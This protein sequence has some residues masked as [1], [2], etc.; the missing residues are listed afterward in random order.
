MDAVAILQNTGHAYNV[1]LIGD[2]PE[3]DKLQQ[4][5]NHLGVS[6]KFY[7][8]CYEEETLARLIMAS[9]ISVAPGMAG[10]TTMQSLA[11]GTPVITHGD[12]KRQA[13]EWEA[14]IPGETGALFDCGSAES[15][16]GAIRAWVIE[17]PDREA[18]RQRC[19]DIIERYFNPHTQCEIIE[20]AIAGKPAVEDPNWESRCEGCGGQPLF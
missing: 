20:R 2:G 3:R 1:L 16:A 11:Y 10:L 8:A 9:D 7:G 13:P 14:I 18:V 6:A 17:N 5:A 15:L 19:Y 12:F 4:Q